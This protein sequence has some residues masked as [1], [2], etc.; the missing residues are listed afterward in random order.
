M[1]KTL[2]FKP[3]AIALSVFFATAGVTNAYAA[4]DGHEQARRL[5]QRPDV[6]ANG[7]RKAS[8]VPAIVRVVPQDAHEQARGLLDRSLSSAKEN[9]A[10]YEYEGAALIVKPDEA[11]D[12]HTQARNL[13]A[14]PLNY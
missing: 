9:G 13:L 6:T 14:R 11:L 5:L 10:R 8:A 7:E 1:S 4:P 2:T 12:A 3:T